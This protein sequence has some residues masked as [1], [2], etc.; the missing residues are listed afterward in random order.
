MAR[1]LE[2]LEMRNE[3]IKSGDS[4]IFLINQLEKR[5][6]GVVEGL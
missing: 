3:D 1:L 2:A 6:E 4:F 5:V